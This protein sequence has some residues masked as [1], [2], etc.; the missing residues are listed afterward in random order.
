MHSSCDKQCA[1]RRILEGE[2]IYAG[3]NGLRAGISC[4]GIQV[5]A[6][7]LIE[8]ALFNLAKNAV[9]HSV[10]ATEFSISC[11]P[12]EE[13]LVIVVEDNGVGI[14]DGEKERIFERG[15]GKHTGLG[16]FM[17]REILGITGM[18]IQETGTAGSG[19]RFAITVP[20]GF[21]RTT[22]AGRSPSP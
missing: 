5:Y 21:F 2:D 7:P 17:V 19:A 9:I 14:P 10:T 20:P 4:A 13:N 18:T 1:L 11:A 12:E 6:D 16:L 3:Q 15:V 8:R 22:P